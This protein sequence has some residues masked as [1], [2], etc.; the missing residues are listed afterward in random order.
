MRPQN[1]QQRQQ[2]QQFTDGYGRSQQQQMHHL[3][4]QQ[5][6]QL[7][8]HAYTP[9]LQQHVQHMHHSQHHQ[10]P[11]QQQ[12]VQQQQH[13]YHSAYSQQ[14]PQYQQQ[15]QQ[16]QQ[17]Q[18]PQV[19]GNMPPPVVATSSYSRPSSYPQPPS[20][21]SLDQSLDLAASMDG[22]GQTSSSAGGPFSSP[23][24]NQSDPFLPDPH[25][26]RIGLLPA[27]PTHTGLDGLDI[28]VG[29]GLGLAP[30][31]SVEPLNNTLSPASSADN[32]RE[33]ASGGAGGGGAWDSELMHGDMNA[34]TERVL[35]QQ[36]AALEA[37]KQQLQQQRYHV[38][39]LQ[40]QAAHR[41]AHLAAVDEGRPLYHQQHPQQQQ[42]QQMQ[43]SRHSFAQAPDGTM[44]GNHSHAA[45]ITRTQTH[46]HP[47]HPLQLQSLPSS[48][49][50][51]AAARSPLSAATSHPDSSP[52]SAPV[53]NAAGGGAGEVHAAASKRK[54]APSALAIASQ[55]S[56]ATLQRM[57][58]SKQPHPH[59]HQHSPLPL[60]ASSSSS[61]KKKHSLA[62]MAAR[63]VSGSS[64]T[65]SFISSAS[66]TAGG[67]ASPNSGK[68]LARRAG[69]VP[70]MQQIPHHRSSS[71]SHK[72]DE[73]GPHP[74]PHS[75]HGSDSDEH[76]GS[77]ADHPQQ[78]DEE[79]DDDDDEDASAAAPSSARGKGRR[80][81]GKTVG[82]GANGGGS[83][84]GL[85]D[86]DIKA[87]RLARKAELARLSRRQKKD[88]LDELEAENE[89]LR[90]RIAQLE[91]RVTALTIE[92]SEATAGTAKKQ[93][94][95][96][97]GQDS[98]PSVAPVSNSSGLLAPGSLMAGGGVGSTLSPVVLPSVPVATSPLALAEQLQG[99]L[100]QTTAHI[101]RVLARQDV[102]RHQHQQQ[103]QNQHMH[104]QPQQRQ[105]HLNHERRA[106]GL[107]SPHSPSA[108]LSPGGGGAGNNAAVSG[109][110]A[111][112]VGVDG[113]EAE[114]QALVNSMLEMQNS[115]CLLSAEMSHAYESMLYTTS[116]SPSA[117]A[118][119]VTLEGGLPVGSGHSAAS[120][121]S[122]STSASSPSSSSS[123]APPGGL[124]PLHFL[125]WLLSQPSSFYSE[126]TGLWRSLWRTE[127]LCDTAQLAQIAQL[128]HQMQ[129][130][131]QSAF[132]QADELHM[133]DVAANA[134]TMNHTTAHAAQMDGGGATAV[135]SSSIAAVA[136]SAVTS[137][138]SSSS[139][140]SVSVQGRLLLSFEHFRSLLM[141]QQQEELS[142]LQ[143]LVHILQPL[144]FAKFAKFATVFGPTVV[145]SHTRGR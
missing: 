98:S 23:L 82:G 116:P 19:Y 43:P 56:E 126:R 50:M 67:S 69:S 87:Q 51:P 102:M 70:Q 139:S 99:E 53:G 121:S 21:M 104:A 123:S 37:H 38:Q 119:N 127:C 134:T 109:V 3:Q 110:G 32:I 20:S 85:T 73:D 105:Q 81:S 118:G 125:Q 89:G 128:R 133:K 75:Y 77:D 78:D 113:T 129:P 25:A 124:M 141:A 28:G 16:Q 46:S 47:H 14:Q 90:A 145:H 91:K 31:D 136:P 103:H 106:G 12:H 33:S 65:N 8:Y 112:G 131:S 93:H 42:Q 29:M 17:H 96:L 59:P 24:R 52:R 40:Q 41:A 66:G 80:G 122:S 4:P 48:A 30:L 83:K 86:Q 1:E 144:Q 88:R 15:Q 9:A 64:P 36:Q 68:P 74:S 57:D 137:L 44:Y 18:A 26:P 92:A 97:K 114:L 49:D 27:S 6:P 71:L 5:P 95:K 132:P 10:Q 7:S 94:K 72:L 100:S 34:N 117:G 55:E 13:A 111:D 107:S 101:L 135:G 130:S 35:L 79:E 2:Q 22:G 58:R 39:L 60:T 63:R 143:Q 76:T 115:R 84:A 11:M 108:I 54:R 62:A 140:S 138:P 142:L 61:A 120:S 45:A